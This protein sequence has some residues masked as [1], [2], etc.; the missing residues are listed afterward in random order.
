MSVVVRVPH[1]SRGQ[2]DGRLNLLVS[3]SGMLPGPQQQRRHPHRQ[4]QRGGRRRDCRRAAGPLP[5]AAAG[6]VVVAGGVAPQLGRGQEPAL[7]LVLGWHRPEVLR[8][9]A[10]VGRTIRRHALDAVQVRNVRVCYE[11]ENKWF[12]QKIY[13]SFKVNM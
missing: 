11:R 8:A 6:P 4:Q 1:I 9:V 2:T 10:S 12:L 3:M 5:P 13:K 7:G